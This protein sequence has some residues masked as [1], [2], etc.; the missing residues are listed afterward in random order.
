MGWGAGVFQFLTLENDAISTS[1]LRD[2][3]VIHFTTNAH[4][5]I[6]VFS[7]LL[8]VKKKHCDD[9]VPVNRSPSSDDELIFLDCNDETG[10][11]GECYNFL[12]KQAGAHSQ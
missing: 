3:P 1:S 5:P 10:R 12:T 6:L 8:H 9:D 4:W 2:C 7:L 11:V